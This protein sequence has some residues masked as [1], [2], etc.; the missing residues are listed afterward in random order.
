MYYTKPLTSPPGATFKTS[1][2]HGF[3]LRPAEEID[4]IIREASEEFDGRS[5]NLLERNCNHFTDWLVEQ[6]TGR[7]APG[8]L[9]RASRVG[10]ALPCVVP[11]EW[12]APP[13]YEDAGGELL[14]DEEE[15]DRRGENERTRM[16]KRPGE[17]ERERESEQRRRR[18]QQAEFVDDDDGH[19]E[20]NSEEERRMGGSGKG[21]KAVRD[22]SG[23]VVPPAERAPIVLH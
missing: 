12:I 15:E 1:I 21:K 6:L 20:W 13:D 10:V 9:N 5:Y 18:D 22:T 4:E 11:R 2:L 3:T 14:M 8:W 23:R 17:R 19:D 7:R 16:L